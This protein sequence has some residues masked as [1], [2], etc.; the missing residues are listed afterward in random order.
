MSPQARTFSKPLFILFAIGSLAL[1]F[2]LPYYFPQAP[3]TSESWIF[4]YNNRA[5]ILIL[6]VSIF[7][8]V[9]WTQ[10]MSLQI[11]APAVSEKLSVKLLFASL[12]AYL[13]G[14]IAMYLFAG[15]YGGFSEAGYF[16]DRIWLVQQGKIP[17]IDFE[18]CFGPSFL[19]G[20][21]LIERIFHVSLI[22][23]YHTFWI[24]NGMVGVLLLYAIV[25]RINFRTSSR[26]SI[27]LILLVPAFFSIFNMGVNYAGP[28]FEFPLYF[29]LVMRS[30]FQSCVLRKRA[31]AALFAV[32]CTGFTFLFS[33]ETPIALTF[34]A[35]VLYLLYTPKWNRGL[36]AIFGCMIL[37]FIGL[38]WKVSQFGVL[39]TIRT[40]GGGTNSFPIVLSPAVL[41]YCAVLFFAACY[42]YRRIAERTFQDDCLALIIYSIPMI[43]AALGRCD[44]AHLL[45]NG[46]GL[47]LA[48]MFY[49]SNHRVA[50]TRYRT[51]FILC[52]ILLPTLTGLLFV[53]SLLGHIGQMNAARGVGD[54]SNKLNLSETYPRWTGSFFV[55]FGFRPNG[56]GTYFSTRIDYGRFDGLLNMNTV[57]GISETVRHMNSHPEMALLLP[58]RFEESCRINQLGEK[59]VVSLLF[60]TAYFQRVAHPNSIRQPI[61]DY[62]LTNYEVARPADEQDFNYGLWVRKPMQKS[63]ESKTSHP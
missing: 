6:L 31:T 16:L 20:P 48:S 57:S 12:L 11:P 22:A 49:W 27:Y 56:V 54:A 13:P 58:S 17:Y 38:F 18:Y 52:F 10:G 37:S 7:I 39:D 26:R 21:I 15:R 3:S 61:C 53:R 23:A 32:L 40:D 28:R 24:L 43:A 44:P 30:I 63:L 2:S 34:T 47:I 46:Q 62:I 5:G 50:W 19:Y 4:G 35:V 51:V 59:L 41:F 25:N 42:T 9:V 29:V 45:N 36:I 60:D 8:G 1:V 33:Q 14:S 55:P